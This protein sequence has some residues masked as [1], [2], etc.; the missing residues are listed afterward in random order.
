MTLA[1]GE[2]MK[3]ARVKTS[4]VGERYEKGHFFSRDG[5][6]RRVRGAG[7]FLR[8]GFSMLMAWND[9]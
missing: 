6:V 9:F 1:E 2:S 7:L 8:V 3:A 4:G 5:K